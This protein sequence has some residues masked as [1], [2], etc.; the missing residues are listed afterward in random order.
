MALIPPTNGA[1][2]FNCIGGYTFN[3]VKEGVLVGKEDLESMFYGSGFGSAT[4]M[5][6]FTLEKGLEVSL[7]P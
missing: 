1:E 2:V 4:E 7:A 5:G 3:D 6:K